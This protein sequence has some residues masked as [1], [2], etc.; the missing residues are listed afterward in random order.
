MTVNLLLAIPSSTKPFEMGKLSQVLLTENYLSTAAIDNIDILHPP[1]STQKDY[2]HVL[3]CGTP[4]E[5]AALLSSLPANPT[6]H[7]VQY[8][9]LDTSFIGNELDYILDHVDIPIF[10]GPSALNL[11]KASVNPTDKMQ[12]ARY[13]AA[14]W[15]FGGVDQI[16]YKANNVARRDL[17]RAEIRQFMFGNLCHDSDFIIMV[18]GP[19]TARKQIQ[20]AIYTANALQKHSQ[21][22]RVMLF[23]HMP[24]TPYIVE[25]IAGNDRRLGIDTFVGDTAMNADPSTIVSDR[26]M[27]QRYQS[28]DVVLVPNMLSA[29]SSTAVEAMAC[30]VPVVG[31]DEHIIGDILSN[32]RGIAIPTEHFV[33]QGGLR[34]RN[35]N[36]DTVAQAIYKSVHE[37]TFSEFI[38]SAQA[39]VNQPDMSWKSVAKDLCKFLHLPLRTSSGS[40][41]A[42]S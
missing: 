28:A 14:I 8:I 38:K 23:L 15:I 30:G 34:I 35:M 16:A 29:W 32:N 22:R 18:N 11:F 3:L 40:E 1:Y 19:F 27:C 24:I 21:K 7:V 25:L 33:N 26:V 42:S 36:P 9:Q 13:R 10:T 2:T 5:G 17:T 20:I 6:R 4:Q 41:Q 39:F 37:D 31:P 12:L